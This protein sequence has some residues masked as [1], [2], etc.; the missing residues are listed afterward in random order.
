MANSLTGILRSTEENGVRSS[1]AKD[2][3][4]EA[5]I[6][7]NKVHK[8]DESEEIEQVHFGKQTIKTNTIR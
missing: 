5:L 1:G 7:H 3:K 6:T 4:L 8:Q 2:G